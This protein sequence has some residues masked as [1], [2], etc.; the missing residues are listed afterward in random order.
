MSETND[1]QTVERIFNGMLSEDFAPS[2]LVRGLYNVLACGEG[3]KKA[4]LTVCR[5]Q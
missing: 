3:H 2:D 5:N 1:I 4:G